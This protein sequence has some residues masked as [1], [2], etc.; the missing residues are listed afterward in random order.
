MTDEVSAVVGNA[1]QK[2]SF[3]QPHREPFARSGC[4]LPREGGSGDFTHKKTYYTVGVCGLKF[5]ITNTKFSVFGKNTVI[6][7]KKQLKKFRF[8]KNI[9]KIY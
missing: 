4:H 7:L 5:N 1:E 8:W 6:F 9:L 3:R 2:N